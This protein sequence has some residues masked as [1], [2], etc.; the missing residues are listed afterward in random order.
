[1]G[2][3]LREDKGYLASLLSQERPLSD[4]QVRGGCSSLTQGC[5]PLTG[6]K[7]SGEPGVSAFLRASAQWAHLMSQSPIPS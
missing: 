2:A 4:F 7:G 5:E 3:D 6:P 1:M